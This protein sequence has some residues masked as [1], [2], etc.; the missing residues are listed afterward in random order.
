MGGTASSTSII[1]AELRGNF[2]GDDKGA[3]RGADRYRTGQI[4][5]G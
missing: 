1:T 2:W 5:V 3:L 4:R